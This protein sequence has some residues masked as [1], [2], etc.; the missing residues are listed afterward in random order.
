MAEAVA[1]PERRGGYDPRHY[2][3]LAAVED[4][5]FWFTG[6]LR[7]IEATIAPLVTMLPGGCRVLEVG[8]GTGQVL[9]MLERLCPHGLVVGMD[10][11]REGLPHARRRT[12]GRIVQGSSTVSPFSAPFDLIGLFDVVEHIDDDEDFLRRTGALLAPGGRLVVTVPAYRRLWSA[13]DER[14]LHCRRYEHEEL[15]MRLAGAGFVVEYLTPFLTTLYPLMRVSRVLSRWRDTGDPMRQELRVVPGLNGILEV[16][17]ALEARWLLARRRRLP[18]G[19]SLI[20]VA[21]KDG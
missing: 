9:Q 15:R 11:L 7:A 19:T 16:L 8:C 20:A 10:L 2:E 18:V 5:H 14:A 3:Q 12:A 1:A 4:R 6:R 17:L 21:R 13:V